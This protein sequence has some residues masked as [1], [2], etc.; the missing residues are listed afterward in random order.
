LL[1]SRHLLT[2][3]ITHVSFSGRGIM[4]VTNFRIILLPSRTPYA[5]RIHSIILPLTH[6]DRNQLK[7]SKPLFSSNFIEGIFDIVQIA[8]NQFFPSNIKQGM[9]KL[10]IESNVDI[11]QVYS[12]LLR[13]IDYVRSI[14]ECG[15]RRY[16]MLI[17]ATTPPASHP[18]SLLQ[19]QIESS[20]FEPSPASSSASS[21]TPF[22]PSSPSMSSGSQHILNN[23]FMD[24]TDDSIIFIPLNGEA[25]FES[26]ARNEGEVES[27][28]AVSTSESDDRSRASSS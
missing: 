11:D 5:S 10:Y 26:A 27:H 16:H 24:A 18:M 2:L 25:M 1:S 19:L 6:I 9:F 14:V 21:S 13:A 3:I 7:C 20:S 17:V 15:G 4:I 23:A 22:V 12:S 8:N 28:Q